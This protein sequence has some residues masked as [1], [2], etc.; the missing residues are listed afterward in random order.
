MESFRKVVRAKA[1]FLTP[2][3]GGRD[4]NIYFE[5]DMSDPRHQEYEVLADFGF[6][7]TE[8]GLPIRAPASGLVVEA[9]VHSAKGAS[10]RGKRMLQKTKKTSSKRTKKIQ[11]CEQVSA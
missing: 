2:E 4:Q 5:V 3:E 8:E 7:Y 9:K 1:H 10:S 11:T 6:G